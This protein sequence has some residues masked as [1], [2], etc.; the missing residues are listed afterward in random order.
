LHQGLAQRPD[1]SDPQKVQALLAL[2]EDYMKAGL[3]DRAEV[4]FTDL[5]RIDQRA[6]QALKHLIGIYQAARDC[7]KA[8]ENAT[9]YEAASGEPVGKVVRYFDSYLAD[10]ERLAGNAGAA[11][12]AV[13]RAYAADATS[14]RAGILEGRLETDAG[15]DA[16]AI[17]AYDRAARH[18]T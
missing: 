11:R 1:L 12:A 17:R 7:A 6:P 3:L 14:G 13:A 16:G 15:D 2:G 8:I 9:R 5:A 18:D 4:V 10:P